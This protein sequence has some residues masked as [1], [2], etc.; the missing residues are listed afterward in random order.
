M[1]HIAIYLAIYV[2]LY[3]RI[4]AVRDSTCN[5]VRNAFGHFIRAPHYF[6]TLGWIGFIYRLMI[7]MG[8]KCFS[9]PSSPPTHGLNVKVTD[10][11]V[12]SC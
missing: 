7:G 8:P 11:E 12:Y 10:L 9:V 4:R 5:V 1:A 3:I 2:N 6:Q